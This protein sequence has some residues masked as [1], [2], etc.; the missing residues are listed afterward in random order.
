MPRRSAGLLSQR[1][2]A[3]C[4]GFAHEGI[5]AVLRIYERGFFK[6][7]SGTFGLIP[8]D[9]LAGPSPERFYA[10]LP[11]A[12]RS[13]PPAPHHA[14][15][16]QTDRLQPPR[17]YDAIEEATTLPPERVEAAVHGI[18]FALAMMN[19]VEVARVLRKSDVP[20]EPPVRHAFQNG[21]VYAL[22]FAEWFCPACWRTGSRTARLKRNW[23]IWP[24]R[25]PPDRWSAA[26]RSRSGWRVPAASRGCG[27]IV[28]GVD[29]D[30]GRGRYASADGACE[31]P[32]R[33]G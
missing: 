19:N 23:S 5:G 29:V 33:T 22:V 27:P 9:A 24:A 25:K 13:R 16:R 8:L 18:A 10:G 12:I 6:I 3:E 31:S 4:L 17:I 30:Q 20:F 28:A 21:L 1:C 14:R 26:C 32:C 15:L 2:A 11:R 7:L